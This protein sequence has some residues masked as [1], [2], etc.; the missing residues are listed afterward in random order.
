MT[1]HGEGHP[2][3]NPIFVEDVATIVVRALESQVPPILNVAGDELLSI[4][5]MAE[6]IG[7]ALGV[8]PLFEHAAGDPPPDLLGD[9]TLLQRT[10]E[11][12]ELTPFEQGIAATVGSAQLP[13]GRART[14]MLPAPSEASSIAARPAPAS[15]SSTSSRSRR[16]TWKRSSAP[17]GTRRLSYQAA[18]TPVKAGLVLSSPHQTAI[19]PSQ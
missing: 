11:L 16:A 10:F 1:L 17:A 18:L 12:G 2:R 15:S 14:N 4:R 8:A 7:K 13:E 5:G 6:T 3:L 9:T 19:S